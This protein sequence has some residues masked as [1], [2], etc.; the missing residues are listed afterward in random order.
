MDSDTDMEMEDVSIPEENQEPQRDFEV[1]LS[2]KVTIQYTFINTLI[3][4]KVWNSDS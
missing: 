4:C 3:Q 1:I 2:Q